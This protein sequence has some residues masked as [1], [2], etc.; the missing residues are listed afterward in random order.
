VPEQSPKDF[1]APT[2]SLWTFTLEKPPPYLFGKFLF[3]LFLFVLFVILSQGRKTPAAR[4]D[5]YLI[6]NTPV[7]VLSGWSSQ[8]AGGPRVEQQPLPR[9]LLSGCRRSGPTTDLPKPKG[10]LHEGPVPT[11]KGNLL[12]LGRLRGEAPGKGEEATNKRR[13]ILGLGAKGPP[14]PG[15]G[16]ENSSRTLGP[17]DRAHLKPR[18]RTIPLPSPARV[19][20]EGRSWSPTP[21]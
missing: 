7:P 1:P 11:L 4:P 12:P 14:S 2:P 18:R 16:R 17:S 13:V 15:T 10:L 8:D 19:P 5:L 20:P 21:G 3:I 6:K 9:H